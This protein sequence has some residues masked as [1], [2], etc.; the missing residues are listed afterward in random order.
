M[1]V[2]PLIF[3]GHHQ[4]YLNNPIFSNLGLCAACWAYFMCHHKLWPTSVSHPFSLNSS[5]GL[6]GGKYYKKITI[7]IFRLILQNFFFFRLLFLYPF[8]WLYYPYFLLVE[9]LL[10]Y[11]TLFQSR[12]LIKY[13]RICKLLQS[14][15]LQWQVNFMGGLTFLFF[16]KSLFLK[17]I[18]GP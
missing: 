3:Y 2:G 8:Q 1:W 4:G 12:E 15:H 6:T 5:S 14:C 18:C 17:V 11:V 16:F 7:A 10:Q 13:K 9:L